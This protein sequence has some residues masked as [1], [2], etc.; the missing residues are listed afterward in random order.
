MVVDE[1]K[2][3]QQ[4]FVSPYKS[5][6]FNTFS[7]IELHQP[8][9][10]KSPETIQEL[11]E[12]YKK[13]Q[14]LFKKDCMASSFDA[15]TPSFLVSSKWLKQY[16]EFILYEQFKMEVSEHDLKVSEDHFTANHP[17]PILNEKDILETD[18]DKINLYGTG[19]IKGYEKEYIDRYIDQQ[20]QA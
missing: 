11:F 7:G 20:N 3:S 10:A 14:M 6:N 19:D 12:E 17:G 13:Y 5:P 8:K 2:V 4:A 18:P 15:G 16:L 9:I 1:E